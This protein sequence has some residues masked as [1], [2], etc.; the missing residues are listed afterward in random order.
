[1]RAYNSTRNGREAWLALIAHFEGDAQ[2]D[3]VKDQ[4]YAAIASAK[5]FGN[6]KKFS[7]E[8]YVTIH[9]ESYSKLEQY[10]EIISEEKRIRDLLMGIKDNS[11]A[12]NAAKGTILATPNLRNNF[13]NAVTHLSTTLQLSQ[14]VQDPQNI[15]AFNTAGRADGVRGRGRN[16]GG[17]NRGGRGSRG[18]GRGRN[19]YLGSYSPEQWRKLSQEDEKRVMD[20][21]QKLNDQNTQGGPR[22]LSS[23]LVSNTDIDHQSQLTGNTATNTQHGLD[24][25]ILQGTLQGS[26]A[27]GDKRRNTE[28]AGSLMTRRRINVFITSNR[29]SGRNASKISHQKY[30]HTQNIIHGPCELDLHADTCVAGSNCVIIE[31]TNQT[32]SVSAFSEAHEIIHNVPIVTAATAYDDNKTGVTYIII[33]GQAIYMGDRMQTSLLCPNQLRANNIRVDDIPK[34]LAPHDQPSTHSIMCHDEDLTL[35]LSLKGIISY[36]DTRTPTQEELD[37]CKWI[38]LGTRRKF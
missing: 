26:A 24:Q 17:R 27:V 20:G 12:T 5:Y 29:A 15:S 32:V 21:R 37:T 11:P 8:T 33:L 4:A 30:E 25:S 35:P 3:R 6:H 28:S 18:R 13:S 14:S 1:M 38:Y 22:N 31:T 16:T 23:V 19:V 2:R 36:I 7:F 10:G 34:H 9:Q